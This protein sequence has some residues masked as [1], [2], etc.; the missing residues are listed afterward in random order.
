MLSSEL[1]EREREGALPNATPYSDS[2]NT[3]I[4]KWN[5]Q[6]GFLWRRKDNEADDDDDDD[7]NGDVDDDDDDDDD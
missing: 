5:I 6:N 7:E 3:V 1:T 4:A 2:N